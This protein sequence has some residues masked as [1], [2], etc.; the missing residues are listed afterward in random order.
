ME[1]RRKM[2]EDRTQVLT[3]D[4]RIDGSM[5]ERELRRSRRHRIANRFLVNAW[6]D[7][8]YPGIGF[9]EDHV[10]HAGE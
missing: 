4:Y 9:G 10:A 2:A 7:E 6:P 8:R 1:H 5:K 3:F